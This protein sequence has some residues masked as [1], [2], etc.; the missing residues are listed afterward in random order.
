MSMSTPALAWSIPSSG[1]FFYTAYD[2]IFNKFLTGPI[3]FIAGG[4]L[5]VFGIILAAK[6]N[7]PGAISMLAAGGVLA[8]ATAIITSVGITISSL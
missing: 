5:M 4:S 1:D 6:S 2:I 3:G 8:N 7:F